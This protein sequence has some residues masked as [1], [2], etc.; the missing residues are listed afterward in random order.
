MTESLKDFFWQREKNK[1]R[2]GNKRIGGTFLLEINNPLVQN[3]FVYVGFFFPFS[4][5]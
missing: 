5:M 1:N 4:N 3:K 2:G